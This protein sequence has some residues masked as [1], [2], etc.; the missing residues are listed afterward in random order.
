MHTQPRA[1]NIAD[2]IVQSLTAVPAAACT[3]YRS[4]LHEILRAH[5]R[6]EWATANCTGDVATDC[7]KWYWY[8]LYERMYERS[9]RSEEPR[10]RSRTR[11]H[12]SVRS[13]VRECVQEKSSPR[14]LSHCFAWETVSKAAVL[15]GAAL[16]KP[17]ERN[18][19]QDVVRKGLHE[20]RSCTREA[21]AREATQEII[22]RTLGCSCSCIWWTN[23]FVMEVAP[24]VKVEAE[25]FSK[26]A[27]DSIDTKIELIKFVAIMGCVVS[28]IGARAKADPSRIQI[29]DIS[30]T[31][32][33][34]R[35][36][37]HPGYY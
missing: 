32:S 3:N 22:V 26:D 14:T 23:S 1:W 20:R 28:S 13:R 37:L 12:H 5:P 24:H 6:T 2:E 27:I 11:R 36:R 31:F 8:K 4:S 16:E 30:D 18:C 35:I 15:W 19:T 10:T 25:L 29:A 17:H 21:A 33:T 34:V 7:A 9:N